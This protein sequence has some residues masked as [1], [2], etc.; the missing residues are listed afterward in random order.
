MIKL[1]YIYIC[2]RIIVLDNNNNNNRKKNKK[3]TRCNTK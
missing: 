1:I 3:T 2:I